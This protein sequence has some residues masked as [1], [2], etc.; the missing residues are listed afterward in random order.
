MS[1][2]L[3]YPDKEQLYTKYGTA[4]MDRNGY[5]KITS[6]KEG[7]Y[8]KWLHRLVYADNFGKIPKGHVVIMKDGDKTNTSPDNLKC[9]SY[10]DYTSDRLKKEHWGKGKQLSERHKVAISKGLKGKYPYPDGNRPKISTVRMQLTRLRNPNTK[11]YYPKVLK[12]GSTV[13]VSLITIGGQNNVL[14]GFR[15]P[16][17]AHER[18]LVAKENRIAELEDL[19]EYLEQNPGDEGLDEH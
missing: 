8:Q 13:Y 3:K 6:G 12:D 11:G 19:L 2:K 5:Y 4:T 17:V 9:L 1:N 10:S 14:G 15:S 18:Y 16:D 7:Y